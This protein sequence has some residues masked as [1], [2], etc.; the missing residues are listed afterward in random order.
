VS[1]CSITTKAN[2][3]M[4]LMMALCGR[5]ISLNLNESLEY[6]VIKRIICE[7][8]LMTVFCS[9]VYINTRIS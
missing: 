9:V 2:Y 8:A 4:Y 7:T 6:V 1:Q 3:H 5:N